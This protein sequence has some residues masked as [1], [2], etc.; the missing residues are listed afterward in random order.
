[1]PCSNLGLSTCSPLQKT[2]LTVAYNL[3]IVFHI[4][5]SMSTLFCRYHLASGNKVL[6]CG[7]FSKIPHSWLHFAG[8]MSGSLNPLA[9]FVDLQS[10]SR[11]PTSHSEVSQISFSELFTSKAHKP[12]T[13][14][15]YLELSL[16]YLKVDRS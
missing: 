5:I 14:N 1:M 11:C 15:V 16:I 3:Y 4:R 6:L 2:P 10:Q 12:K 8:S 9:S 13:T 7:V